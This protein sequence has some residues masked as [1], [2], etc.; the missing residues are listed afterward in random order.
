MQPA[1]LLH[2]QRWPR[3][4]EITVCELVGE[5]ALLAQLGERLA[6]LIE[7]ALARLD[8]VEELLLAEHREQLRVGDEEI[9][10]VLGLSNSAGRTSSA[11]EASTACARSPSSSWSAS[12][13]CAST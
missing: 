2:G 1:L 5:R 7:S 12:S 8:A 9:E 11:S 13:T 4:Q 3:P 10:L 6:G